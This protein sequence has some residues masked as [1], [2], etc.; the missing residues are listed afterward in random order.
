MEGQEEQKVDQTFLSAED[1]LAADDREYATVPVPEWSK[2]N[3]NAVVRIRSWSAAEAMQFV[4][5]NENKATQKSAGVRM[6]LMSACNE[7][8][9]LIFNRQQLEALK[10]RSQKALGRVAEAV[11]ALNDL[12]IKG[13]EA[14]L[15]SAKND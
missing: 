2:T 9:E 8:G 12:T 11:M 10:T 5:S 13:A 3:P 14:A 15:E 4:E 1:I 7:K 6:V